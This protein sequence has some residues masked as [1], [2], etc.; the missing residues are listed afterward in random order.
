MAYES[1]LVVILIIIYNVNRGSW[2]LRQRS[3]K[4]TL[5]TPVKVLPMRQAKVLRLQVIA[6]SIWNKCN[7]F[8]G[9]LWTR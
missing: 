7:F 3:R 8:F 2:N 4:S 9:S 5:L 1:N 6:F